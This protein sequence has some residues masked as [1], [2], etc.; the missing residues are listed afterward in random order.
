MFA[1]IKAGVDLNTDPGNG[2]GMAAVMQAIKNGT[3]SEAR[4]RDSALR[5]VST[6]LNYNANMSTYANPAKT[7]AKVVRQPSTKNTIRQ[8]GAQSIC[9]LKNV[10]DALPLKNP[11]SIGVFGANAANWGVGPSW[12]TDVFADLG[13]TWPYH[14]NTGGGSG[15]TQSPYLVSPLDALTQRAANS[16]FDINYMAGN[17]WTLYNSGVFPFWDPEPS[18]SQWAEVSDVCLV[19]INAYSKEGA[20]RHMLSDAAQDSLVND[21]AMFCNNTI[22]VMNTVGARVVDAWINNPNVTVSRPYKYK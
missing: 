8:A 15:R 12:P 10:R 22:V 18:L 5:T 14:L 6:Q 16:T 4:L 11:Q 13:D 20:D 17:N 1:A 21:V 19:F 3:L 9:L 2:T 7:L